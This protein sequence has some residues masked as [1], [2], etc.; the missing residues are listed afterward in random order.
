MSN[1]QKGSNTAT[2]SEKKT[3]NTSSRTDRSKSRE[4]LRKFLI[5]GLQDIYW[6][7]K[8]LEKALKKME[9]EATTPELKDA[10]DEHR[11]QTE[12]HASRLEKAFKM[13]DEEPKAKK[14]EAM[15]GLI[16][17]AEEIIK[18]TEEGSMTRDAALIIAAQKVEHYEIASYGGLV[19]IALTLDEESLARL[20]NRILDEEEQT[21]EELTY[22][23]ESF[24][25]F[26]AA[27][28]GDDGNQ[29]DRLENKNSDNSNKEKA[30]E[31]A[32]STTSKSD[33]QSAGNQ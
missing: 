11:M 24:I 20:L 27:N 17:E 15:A 8:A 29:N 6:A 22:I 25:N 4:P 5:E 23:A 3:T 13:L 1:T 33:S 30:E 14:C 21:D 31:K 18:S 9:E 2:Q 28:E 7:E 16:K 26:E 19:Q 10:F 32:S 12:R